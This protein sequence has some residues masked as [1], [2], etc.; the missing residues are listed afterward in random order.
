M[1]ISDQGVDITYRGGPSQN[2]IRAIQRTCYT[3]DR[4]LR[5]YRAKDGSLRRLKSADGFAALN[6]L[7]EG[8][9]EGVK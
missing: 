6:R 2:R 1:M 3:D 8:M 4:G 9:L 7:L 5:W